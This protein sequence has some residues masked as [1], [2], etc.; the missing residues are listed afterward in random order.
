MRTRTRKAEWITVLLVVVTWGL[1]SHAQVTVGD[2]VEMGLS[3]DASVGWAGQWDGEDTSNLSFGFNGILKGSYYNSKFLN[4]R[5]NPYYNQSRFN[6]NFNSL[7]SAKGLN[8]NVGLFGGSKT[9]IEFNFQ[10]A[11]D[12][13]SQ[14]N[15]PGTTGTYESRGDTTSFDVNAGLYY[16]DYPTLN[17]SVGKSVSDFEVLGT[18]TTG[19]GDSRFLTMGSSYTLA[20]FDLSGRFVSN[21]IGN[22][23]PAVSGFHGEKVNSYQKGVTV[24]ATRKGPRL[25]ALGRSVF[26]ESC[27][28]RLRAQSDKREL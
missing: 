7:S 23:L 3:G 4:W 12:A 10:K 19:S 18:D 21:R 27:R 11:Y 22:T 13:E 9:P 5:I 6:S 20:G 2:N 24:S 1:I 25:D 17:I 28:H 16:E 8:A 14:I 26:A 15:F